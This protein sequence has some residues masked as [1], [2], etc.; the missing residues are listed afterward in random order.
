M[1]SQTTSDIIGRIERAVQASQAR[2]STHP[3]AAQD[4]HHLNLLSQ[5]TTTALQRDEGGRGIADL[6]I[7]GELER[8]ARELY[9]AQS[10]RLIW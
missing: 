10:V 6:V 5:H 8:A 9:T 1:T 4:I 7:P 2:S 3:H